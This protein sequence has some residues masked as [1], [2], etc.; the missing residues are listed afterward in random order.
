[1]AIASQNIKTLKNPLFE[2]ETQLQACEAKM[3]SENFFFVKPH[4]Y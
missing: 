2:L 1:M 3:G 4:W